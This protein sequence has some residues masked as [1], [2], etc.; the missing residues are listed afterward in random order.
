M[1]ITIKQQNAYK[2]VETKQ[3]ITEWKICQNGNEEIIKDFLELK[4]NEYTIYRNYGT[5][6]R[7]F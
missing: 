2:L 7:L 5:Q 3:L 4:K 6:W 1:L